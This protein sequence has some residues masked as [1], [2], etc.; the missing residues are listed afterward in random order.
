MKF[1]NRQLLTCNR[2]ELQEQLSKTSS[3]T[4]PYVYEKK[5][6]SMMTDEAKT[7]VNFIDHICKSVY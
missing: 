7:G 6:F 3:T 1:V 5:K 2:V 4:P